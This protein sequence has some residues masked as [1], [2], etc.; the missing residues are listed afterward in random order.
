[1]N[2]K[3]LFEK[4]PYLESDELILKKVEDKDADDLFEILTNENVFKYRPIIR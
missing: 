4:F 2:K 1:M 3:L